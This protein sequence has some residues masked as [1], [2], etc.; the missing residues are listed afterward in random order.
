M[1]LIKFGK[2]EI[3]A[4]ENK[5]EMLRNEIEKINNQCENL[6]VLV[7][8]KDKEIV[9]IQNQIRKIKGQVGDIEKIKNENKVLR[10]I[11]EHSSRHTK[12]TVKNL[13]MIARLKAEG[14]S[15]RA[16][17]KALSESTGDDFAHSTVSYLYA[18]Y[19]KNSVQGS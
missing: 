3:K 17:A 7:I 18:K 13:E 12:A 2:K 1:A 10:N 4:L 15:Y 8:E 6:N 9:S 5:N 16:I 19:I 11:L 14:K